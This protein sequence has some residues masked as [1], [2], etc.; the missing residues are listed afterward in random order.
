VG[1]R[2]KDED[3]AIFGRSRSALQAQS[4]QTGP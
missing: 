2:G 3:A 1:R 4:D